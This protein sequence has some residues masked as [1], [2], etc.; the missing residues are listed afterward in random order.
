MHQRVC[1]VMNGALAHG[2]LV[3]QHPGVV[4]VCVADEEGD[5]RDPP[6]AVPNMRIPGIF[7]ISEVV[8]SSSSCSWADLFS[9][10]S[11]VR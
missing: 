5:F 3:E 10:P 6:G 4:M 2:E 7:I 9:I 11:E 1:A 8:H